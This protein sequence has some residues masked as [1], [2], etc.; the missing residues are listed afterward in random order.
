MVF[1]INTGSNTTIRDDNPKTPV[2]REKNAIRL[3]ESVVNL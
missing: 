2:D 3:E 1:V